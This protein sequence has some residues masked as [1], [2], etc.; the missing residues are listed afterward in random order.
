MTNL[1]I[2]KRYLIEKLSPSTVNLRIQTLNKYLVS[3]SNNWQLFILFL[4][5]II[6]KSCEIACPIILK[7]CK[8]L[9]ELLIYNRIEII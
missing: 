1:L 6:L 2:F 3:L 5:P 7:S 9:L 4:R 8:F